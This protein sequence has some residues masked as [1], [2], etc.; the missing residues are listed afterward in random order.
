MA[1]M[2]TEKSK[3]LAFAGFLNRLYNVRIIDIRIKFQ[4]GLQKV[5]NIFNTVFNTGKNLENSRKNRNM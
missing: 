2:R 1:V 3:N 4:R 5:I